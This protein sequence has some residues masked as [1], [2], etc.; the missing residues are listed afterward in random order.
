MSKLEN[1]EYRYLWA[2]LL[3]GRRSLGGASYNIRTI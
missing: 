1:P 2:P 3:S